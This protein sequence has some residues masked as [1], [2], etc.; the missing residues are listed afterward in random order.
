[1]NELARS[2]ESLLFYFAEP[3]RVTE[4]AKIL[5]RERVEVDAALAELRN[6]L[7]DR[8][9][10]LME[11]AGEVSLVTAPSAAP[12]IEA[13]VKEE[14]SKDLSRASLETLSVVLYRGPI[15]RSEIDHIRGVNSTFIL[16]TLMVRGLVEKL[17]NPKDQRS[18]LYRATSDTLRFMGVT[19]TEE[20]PRFE[21]TRDKIE[22]IMAMRSPEADNP[23]STPVPSTEETPETEESITETDEVLD[24]E[25]EA[26]NYEENG[27]EQAP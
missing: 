23:E 15:T 8:G 21:E 18:Y 24:R 17:D 19:R 26:P 16:R 22:Q 25:L 20:L 7:S 2:I 1:M 14:L 13:V 10:R 3:I 4:L 27:E 11:H 5:K 9:I 6:S 12:L